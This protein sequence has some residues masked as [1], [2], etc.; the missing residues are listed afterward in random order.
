MSR[1]RCDQMLKEL[2]NWGRWGKDDQLGAL[3]LITPAKRQQAIALA[4][5]G[6]QMSLGHDTLTPPFELKMFIEPANSAPMPF[7]HDRVEIDF[8]G[9]CF[10]ALDV[11]T[12]TFL[13]KAN[14]GA[15]IVN[16]PMTYAVDGKQYVVT[17]SGQSI[18]A[19][20]LRD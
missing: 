17:I 9:G 3:N 7:V 15:Q 1:A 14:L 19:F 13:W 8:H 4:K 18:V 11:S 16:G 10:Q 12:G 5:S 2:S 20:G 6:T